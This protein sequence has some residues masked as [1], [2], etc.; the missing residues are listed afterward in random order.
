MAEP[1]FEV[2]PDQEVYFYYD[3]RGDLNHMLGRRL[4]LFVSTDGTYAVTE[5]LQL[6]NHDLKQIKF[7]P[8]TLTI[9]D[10][11]AEIDEPLPIDISDIQLNENDHLYGYIRL[12]KNESENSCYDYSLQVLVSKNESEL[13]CDNCYKF[14]EFVRKGQLLVPIVYPKRSL[15]VN[16]SANF[17]DVYKVT[18]SGDR[19]VPYQPISKVLKVFLNGILLEENVDYVVLEDLYQVEFLRTLDSGE[20]VIIRGLA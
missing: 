17:I 10:R 12:H 11:I 7:S 9:D 1:I 2:V 18:N 16:I 3:Q 6:L 20:L 13:Q 4:N 19:L 14:F 5:G 8:G 15:F